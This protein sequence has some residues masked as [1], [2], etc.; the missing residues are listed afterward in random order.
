MASA[1]KISDQGLDA[2]RGAIQRAANAAIDAAVHEVL[3]QSATALD[4]AA[5]R[6][7]DRSR[8]VE[9]PKRIN[10]HARVVGK[11]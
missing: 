8:T 3:E 4:E 5:E 2:L 7:R 11:R 10:V 1:R 9:T 6:L